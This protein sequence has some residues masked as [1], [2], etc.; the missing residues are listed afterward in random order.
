MKQLNLLFFLLCAGV[1]A[2][3]IYAQSWVFQNG[4]LTSPSNYVG[5]LTANPKHPLQIGSTLGLNDNSINYNNVTQL[6]VA[7]GKIQ[8]W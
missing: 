8:Q 2:T 3:P 5:V 7:I 1:Y 4:G 6:V